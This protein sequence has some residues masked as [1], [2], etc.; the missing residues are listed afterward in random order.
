V[1]PH[2]TDQ[3]TAAFERPAFSNR[4]AAIFCRKFCTWEAGMPQR[5]IFVQ[6]SRHG[7]KNSQPVDVARNRPQ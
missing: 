1:G 2:P 6:S 5:R 4:A 3:L 7:A